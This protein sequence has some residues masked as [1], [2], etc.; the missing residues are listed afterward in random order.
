MN[1]LTYNTA[2]HSGTGTGSSVGDAV[3]TPTPVS[4]RL[5]VRDHAGRA[6]PGGAVSGALR[7]VPECLRG[8]SLP[9]VAVA[10]LRSFHRLQNWIIS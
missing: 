8:S 1:E 2:T 7:K 3:R 10:G 6:N 5:G 9:R 4:T